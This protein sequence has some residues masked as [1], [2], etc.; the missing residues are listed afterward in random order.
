MIISLICF[1]VW[2]TTKMVVT[3]VTLKHLR[4]A[5]L[6]AAPEHFNNRLNELKIAEAKLMVNLMYVWFFVLAVCVGFGLLAGGIL[7]N[8]FLRE[9]IYS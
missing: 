8:G 4:T 5:V 7:I 1:I 2:E 6:E 3:T 9:L